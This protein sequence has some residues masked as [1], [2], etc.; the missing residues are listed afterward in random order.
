MVSTRAGTRAK[1]DIPLLLSSSRNNNE[2]AMKQDIF[3]NTKC[4]Y[5]LPSKRKAPI[6]AIKYC[7]VTLL[8]SYEL[9]IPSFDG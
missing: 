8:L 4:S 3:L 5:A 9:S 7:K 1:S 2:N 6:N